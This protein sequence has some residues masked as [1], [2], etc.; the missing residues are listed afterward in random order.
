MLHPCK[1]CGVE[2]PNWSEIDGKTI[3]LTRRSYCLSCSPYRGMKGRQ[4]K[5]LDKYDVINGIPHKWCAFDKHWVPCTRFRKRRYDGRCGLQGYCQDCHIVSK[6]RRVQGLK[7]QAI[8]YKGSR[9]F[10]CRQV[11]PGYIYD[12]HHVDPTTK[13]FKISSSKGWKNIQSELDKCIMLCAHCHRH[14]H[15]DK[16]NPN[17]CPYR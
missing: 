4:S 6:A 14:R 12:F 7:A 1:Q 9:C 8:I 13:E 11:F 5:R 10:D 16:N 2:I 3:S 17:Y 15:H